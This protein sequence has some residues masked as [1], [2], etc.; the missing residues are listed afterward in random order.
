MQLAAGEGAR[1]NFEVAVMTDE[2]WGADAEL[3]SKKK[4]FLRKLRNA[5]LIRTYNIVFGSIPSSLSIS[6][7]AG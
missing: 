4:T 6:G 5:H 2:L 3:T 1:V 7:Q